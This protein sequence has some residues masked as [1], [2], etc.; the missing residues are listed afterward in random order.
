MQLADPNIGI[1]YQTGPLDLAAK[2]IEHQHLRKSGRFLAPHG[3][4]IFTKSS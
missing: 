4:T 2:S 1:E 3:V